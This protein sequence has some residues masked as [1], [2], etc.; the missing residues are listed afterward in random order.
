MN[1][2][3]YLLLFAAPAVSSIYVQGV[4]NGENLVMQEKF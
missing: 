2:S 1:A 3:Q 4:E